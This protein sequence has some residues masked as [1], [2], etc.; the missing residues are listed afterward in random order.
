MPDDVDGNAENVSHGK[1]GPMNDG[2]MEAVYFGSGY[3]P[4]GPG[5]GRG[6][7][8]GTWWWW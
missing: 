4:N 6:P 1:A 7:W 2:S 8:I 3:G 5:S